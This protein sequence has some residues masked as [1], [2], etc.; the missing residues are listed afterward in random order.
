MICDFSNSY[1][2]SNYDGGACQSTNYDTAGGRM[3]NLRS[4]YSGRSGLYRN[5]SMINYAAKI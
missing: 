4:S 1:Y 3:I 5:E 2:R